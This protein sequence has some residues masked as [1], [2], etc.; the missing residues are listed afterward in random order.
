MG[1]RRFPHCFPNRSTAGSKHLS[2]HTAERM[3]E[4]EAAAEAEAEAGARLARDRAVLAVH[5]TFV[6]VDLGA[7]RGNAAAFASA[8]SSR[9]HDLMVVVKANGYG[10]GAAQA[11][12]AALDGGAKWLAVARACEAVELREAGLHCP[13]LV[14]GITPPAAVARL[15]ALGVSMA[16]VDAE[17]ARAAAE[18]GRAAGVRP[19]VHLKVDCGMGRLGV[20]HGRAAEEARA[21]EEALEAAGG[22]ALEGVFSHFPLADEDGAAEEGKHAAMVALF[23]SVVGS[24]RRR[25]AVVHAGNSATSARGTVPSSVTVER[26]GIS[27]YGLEPCPGWRHRVPGVRPALRWVARLNQV[28]RQPPGAGISY[29]HHYTVADGGGELVGTVACG[30]H[31][32]VRRT[33]GNRVVLPGGTEAPVLGRVCMDQLMVSLEGAPHARPGDPV[34]ILC[35]AMPASALAARW[36][37]IDYEVVCGIDSGRVPRVYVDSS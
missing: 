14:L 35:E 21:C 7:L 4:A 37:T 5:D 18:A 9:A 30:Y 32:G 2:K 3:S 33:D 15:V 36:H 19:R 8:A 31:D 6:E 29:G 13:V 26:V 23:D 16:V 34:Q 24:L 22:A 20:A 17:G 25:P 11:G 1:E 28:R 10:H 12:R 27:F